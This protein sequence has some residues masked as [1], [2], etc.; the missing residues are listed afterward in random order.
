MKTILFV[1][2][3]SCGCA[4][5][6]L[7]PDEPVIPPNP[8]EGCEGACS[9]MQ[10]LGCPGWEDHDGGQTCVEF[11]ETYTEDL[12]L[13]PNCIADAGGCDIDH[14]DVGYRE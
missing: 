12:Y 8:Y 1:F 7:A 6:D 3:L 5:C 14:C 11:C 9:R 13:D 4:G 2:M 10:A